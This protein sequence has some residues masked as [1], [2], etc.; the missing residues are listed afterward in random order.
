MSKKSLRDAAWM[1]GAEPPA[2]P[3]GTESY[4]RRLTAWR[5]MMLEKNMHPIT[6]LKLLRDHTCGECA[7]HVRQGGT[8][9]TYHKCRLNNTGGP[10]TD[11]R[12]SWPACTRFEPEA[13]A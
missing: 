6:R 9:G 12:V 2:I 13:E 4:E 11:L 5:R 7:H 8:S 3:D 1:V 10:K